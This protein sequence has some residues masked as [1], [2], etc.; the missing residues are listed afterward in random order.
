MDNAAWLEERRKGIGGSDIAAIMGLS[1]WTTAYKIYQN[2][3]GEVKEYG[4][5]YS[6]VVQ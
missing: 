4:E 3:R 6:K 5:R 2:K 1:H